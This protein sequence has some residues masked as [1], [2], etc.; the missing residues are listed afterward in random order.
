[1]L[2]II[3]CRIEKLLELLIQVI[4]VEK[5]LWIE[6][7][8]LLYLDLPQVRYSNLCIDWKRTW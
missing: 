8:H 3:V 1:M 5:L 4:F 2:S 6:E 7:Y